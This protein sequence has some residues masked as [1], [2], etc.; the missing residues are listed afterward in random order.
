MS[1]RWDRLIRPWLLAVILAGSLGA[2]VAAQDSILDRVASALLGGSAFRPQPLTAED[3]PIPV[4]RDQL[5]IGITNA[6]DP[7]GVRYLAIR[8]RFQN[9]TE[10]PLKVQSDQC[11]IVLGNEV[12]PRVTQPAQLKEMPVALIG[13]DSEG[14]PVAL[15]GPGEF[16]VAP[17]KFHTAWMIFA[18]LPP[19]RDLS[20]VKLQ[21]KT[22]AGPIDI[23]LSEREANRLQVT[24]ERIG[25]RGCVNVCRVTGDLNILNLPKLVDLMSLNSAAGRVISFQR[26]A[27]LRDPLI[28]EW[29]LDGEEAADNERLKYLPA[30]PQRSQS[31]VIVGL[32]GQSDESSDSLA[33]TES[34]AVRMVS[35]RLIPQLDTVTLR[36]ELR[37]GHPDF[38]QA[39]LQDHGDL[40]AQVE[41]AA[42]LAALND[43]AGSPE[44]RLSLI[45]SLRSVADPAAVEILER[46]VRSGSREE[47]TWA[48]RSLNVS[49]L[50]IARP[51]AIE[52]ARNP[53]VRKR[54]GLPMILRSVGVEID[55]AWFPFLDEAFRDEDPLAR[56]LALQ[57]LLSQGISDRQ[58][59]LSKAFSDRSAEVRET[60]YQAIVGQRTE[61]EQSL[62]EDETFR[63]FR[64]GMRDQHTLA[65]IAELRDPQAIPELLQSIDS[66]SG[67]V[68]TLVECCLMVGGNDVIPELEKRLAKLP[69]SSQLELLRVMHER[70]LESARDL[71][72]SQLA[73][74]DDELRAMSA[75]VLVS[76]GDAKCYEAL[77]AHLG[78]HADDNLGE[79]AIRIVGQAL[80]P[81]SKR[82]LQSLG[83]EQ[84]PNLRRLAQLGLIAQNTVH[85]NFNWR[86]VANDL[87][88]DGEFEAAIEALKLAVETDD[89]DWFIINN[90]GFAYLQRSRPAEAM[91]WFQRS[92][93]LNSEAHSS[94]TGVAIC[95]AVEGK[96]DEAIQMV[97]RQ[98][99]LD[100][101]GS[102]QIYLYNIACVYGRSAEYL[103]KQPPAPELEMRRRVLEDRA[104][105]FLKNSI[106]RGFQDLKL[107]EADPDLNSLRQLPAFQE[108][109]QR[110]RELDS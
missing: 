68:S 69:S 101:W 83:Q 72:M 17:G 38:R 47:A 37:D 96:I 109:V 110:V 71:A 97:D 18:P 77:R 21:L 59:I 95:L 74:P 20:K 104:I 106:D 98:E 32:P 5:Q 40:V 62:F 88:N 56:E 58:Q 44:L 75:H 100:R 89:Q 78:K 64:A 28:E 63:R 23:D 1:Q 57:H 4:S 87:T 6:Y 34:Q 35:R 107:F 3:A 65:G 39:I 51:R 48:L 54:I 76:I 92:L 93:Q 9:R 85:P 82:L 25:P 36:Q 43:E 55:T 41:P 22:S 15:Q 12:A 90:L 91:P 7:S 108:L 49:T 16:S 45:H 26:G 2:E 53:E 73:S 27:L 66:Q 31:T 103:T 79:E 94:L 33:P 13:E 81:E 8:L 105:H 60:A 80:T 24:S 52:L 61:D 42:L 30:W 29:L 84:A 50:A 46:I 19:T 67:E 11:Q 10:K 70:G 99:L 14:D 102:E 86:E